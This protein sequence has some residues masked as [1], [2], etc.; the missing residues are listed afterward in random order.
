MG[1]SIECR[2][3]FLDYRL[4]EGLAALPSSAL[5][6]GRRGKR[7]LL[8]AV[9]AR[10]PD[11]I[12]RAGKR[13]FSVPWERHLRENAELREIIAGLPDN[14]AVQQGPF[15]RHK[16]RRVV[17]A[18]LAGSR[19]REPLMVALFMVGIWHDAYQGRLADLRASVAAQPRLAG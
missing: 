5:L 16:V 12:K 7:L 15:E 4:V 6:R 17:N 19:E 18:F 10:L 9:G 13:G 3:P 8:D 14:D 1:A 11:G 2:V